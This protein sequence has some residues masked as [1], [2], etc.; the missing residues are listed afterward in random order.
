MARK[1]A[2]ESPIDTICRQEQNRARMAKTRALESPSEAS[3]RQEKN[4][5]QMATRR[6]MN[7]SVDSAITRFLSKT[8]LGPD[9]VCTC[10][11]RMM[12]KQNVV[13][14]STSKYSKASKEL[15]NQV[16]CAEHSYMSNDG[17]LWL[18]SSCDLALSRGNMP[19][20]AKANN[21]QLDEVPV[22]LSTLN[23]LELRLIS[24]RVPF[25]KMVALPFGKGVF[26]DQ[27]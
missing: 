17:N 26:K 27:L 18:C 16:F 19:V 15:L 13:P 5:T 6:T 9:F 1:R 25:M 22:E 11:H 12:Y 14:C 3:H 8:K 24:L 10:C 20:Q 21:L 23:A 4:R 2:L 7:V